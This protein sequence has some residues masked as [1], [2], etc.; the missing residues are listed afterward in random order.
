[1][2]L[3]IKY[4]FLRAREVKRSEEVP[5]YHYPQHVGAPLA[6]V[7]HGTG[8]DLGLQFALPAPTPPEK[9]VISPAVQAL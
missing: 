8:E 5:K 4:I 9:N 3:I 2:S 1:M 7:G 6:A